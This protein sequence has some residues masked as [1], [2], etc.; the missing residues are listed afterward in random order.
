MRGPTCIVWANLTPLLA[1]GAPVPPLGR[2]QPAAHRPGV[3]SVWRVRRAHPARSASRCPILHSSSDC[4]NPTLRW[5]GVCV[6][7]K[8]A[9]LAQKMQ[10]CPCSPVGMQLL[11]AEVGPSSGPTR[12]SLS[13]APACRSLYLRPLR[14]HAAS[15]LLRLRPRPLQEDQGPTVCVCTGWRCSA[16]SC[17]PCG[18]SPRRSGSRAP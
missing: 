2:L 16:L 8:G 12:A 17:R 6:R 18:F 13:P 4:C 1:P 11:K 14:P 10:L 5:R 9:R 3:G 15:R 7:E